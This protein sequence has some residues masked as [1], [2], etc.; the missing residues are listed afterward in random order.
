MFDT[1]VV[2]K[3]R[4]KKKKKERERWEECSTGGGGKKKMLLFFSSIIDGQHVSNMFVRSMSV[5]EGMPSADELR[6]SGVRSD[7]G[8]AST[9]PAWLKKFLGCAKEQAVAKEGEAKKPEQVYVVQG[10]P[11]LPRKMVERIERGK[12]VEFADFPIFDGGR[13]QGEW[14]AERSEKDSLSPA[15][16]TSEHRRKAP[17]EVPDVSWWGIGDHASPCMRG[18]E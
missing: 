7:A 6:S 17:R 12:F 9:E 10:L 15:R 3:K 4:R 11:P 5:G 13:R 16:Q 18:L 1:G 14:S 8:G 2:Q